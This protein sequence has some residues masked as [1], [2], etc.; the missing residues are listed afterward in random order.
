MS[1][2]PDREGR[3]PAWG[4]RTRASGTGGE[5]LLPLALGQASP[6]S[7][8]FVDLQGM[9]PAFEQSGA[10]RADGLGLRFTPRPCRSPL[11]LRVE[12]IR[13]GH[14]ATGGVQ[15]PVPHVRIGPRKSPGVSHHVPL[16][17]LGRPDARTADEGGGRVGRIR[18]RRRGP[19]LLPPDPLR[20]RGCSCL[21]HRTRDDH[22]QGPVWPVAD[23]RMHGWSRRR[24]AVDGRE[25]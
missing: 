19:S 14:P 18:L 3:A 20:C 1:A 21:D 22:D 24:V 15:L 12:E 8:R 2:T 10:S 11:T 9:S 5:D 13:T 25:E 17:D 4:T 7:V 23:G 16:C 6:D